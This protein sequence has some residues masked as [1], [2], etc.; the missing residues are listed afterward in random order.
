MK[1]I[2]KEKGNEDDIWR[3]EIEGGKEGQILETVRGNFRLVHENL[4]CVLT[5]TDHIYPEWGF[6][7]TEVACNPKL[8]DSKSQWHIDDN[9]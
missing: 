5:T 7:S 2:Q 1:F 4:K 6:G 3:L 9:R 8:D